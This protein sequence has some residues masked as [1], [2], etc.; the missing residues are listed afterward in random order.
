MP[1]TVS[2][3]PVRWPRCKWHGGGDEPVERIEIAPRPPP[4][5]IRCVH[6]FTWQSCSSSFSQWL[7]QRM[8][9][10]DRYSSRNHQIES[11]SRTEPELSSNARQEETPN[12]ISFGFVL[13]EAL[14]GMFL[15]SDRYL[16]E[17]IT[18]AKYLFS[19]HVTHL[20]NDRLIFRTFTHAL[21]RYSFNRSM[22][23]FLNDSLCRS[24]RTEIW[25]SPLSAP[26][27]IVK[28]FMLR[29]TAVW[30]APQQVQFTAEMLTWEPVSGCPL[31]LPKL[32]REVIAPS[33]GHLSLFL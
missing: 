30:R 9:R 22:R 12:R 15:D 1:L 18:I 21:S 26:R 6:L 27:I 16:S 10:W 3:N 20:C 13:T 31:L 29:F 25:S 8:N 7:A 11:T 17:E 2:I 32:R 23:W 5:R 4:V 33:P 14:L 28:R 19:F 24:C